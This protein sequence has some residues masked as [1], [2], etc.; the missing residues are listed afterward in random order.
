MSGKKIKQAQIT[1]RNKYL[2]EKLFFIAAKKLIRFNSKGQFIDFKTQS[3]TR[4]PYK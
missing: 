4:A 2:N 3:P 1:T